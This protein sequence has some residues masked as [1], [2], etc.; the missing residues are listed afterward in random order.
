MEN[1][2]H[3]VII[4]NQIRIFLDKMHKIKEENARNLFFAR[5]KEN[6][7]NGIYTRYSGWIGEWFL[8]KGYGFIRLSTQ[9][10]EMENVHKDEHGYKMTIFALKNEIKSQYPSGE[11]SFYLKPNPKFEGM[12]MAKNIIPKQHHKWENT[13]VVGKIKEISTE[14]KTG[15]IQYT[16][17]TTPTKETIYHIFFHLSRC[18]TEVKQGQD[19]EFNVVA[20]LRKKHLLNAIDIESV[21][22]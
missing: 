14:N 1:V 22:V 20:N 8:N 12:Y 5:E 11:V 17:F 19:V 9:I 6:Q 15:I 21:S 7:D 13:R 2:S 16:D 3:I 18:F 4:Q 10:P